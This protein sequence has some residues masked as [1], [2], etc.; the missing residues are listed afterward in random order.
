MQCRRDRMRTFFKNTNI[1]GEDL[2]KLELGIYNFT[3]EYARK[4]GI[5]LS[6]KSHHFKDVYEKKGLS[7]YQNIVNG[8]I[9]LEFMKAEDIAYMAPEQLKPSLWR[10]LIHKNQEKIKNSYEIHMLPMSDRIVCRKCKRKNIVY[11]EYQSRKADEGSSTAYTCL[12]CNYKWK[13]N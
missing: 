3:I 8:N 7:I 9:N 13:K 1:D 10:E 6:W 5:P 12:D 2:R 11:Y 4:N